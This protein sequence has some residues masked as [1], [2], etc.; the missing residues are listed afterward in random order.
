[1]VPGRNPV[2]K[3]RPVSSYVP[4]SL[5]SPIVVWIRWNGFWSRSA[6]IPECCTDVCCSEIRSN[7]RRPTVMSW[8]KK[9]R[10][11]HIVIYVS[12]SNFYMNTRDSEKRESLFFIYNILS[13]LPTD[14]WFV[15]GVCNRYKKIFF[16][17][18][19]IVNY[20]SIDW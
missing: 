8:K 13:W 4:W 18:F 12:K 17:G 2:R 15:C 16:G 7:S 10:Y 5:T 14:L 20:Y 11:F 9:K 3:A 19:F 6:E 1:M